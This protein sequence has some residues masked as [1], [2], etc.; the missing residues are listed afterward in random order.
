[1]NCLIKIETEG[2]RCPKKKSQLRYLPKEGKI[3]VDSSMVP[4]GSSLSGQIGMD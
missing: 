2:Y 1:M 3:G 4:F